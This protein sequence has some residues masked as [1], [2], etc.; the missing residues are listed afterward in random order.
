MQLVASRLRVQTQATGAAT[1]PDWPSSSRLWSVVDSSGNL[2]RRGTLDNLKLGVVIQH[3]GDADRC[4]LGGEGDAGVGYNLDPI[5]IFDRLSL[6]T[7]Q[8]DRVSAC[9]LLETAAGGSSCGAF[10]VNPAAC[11]DNL[12][13]HLRHLSESAFGVHFTV[14]SA[15]AVQKPFREIHFLP[16]LTIAA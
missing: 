9:G 14:D 16:A 11:S 13:E 4:N 10:L 6:N 15:R 12:F 3:G 7:R 5:F 1:C 8:I 2:Q